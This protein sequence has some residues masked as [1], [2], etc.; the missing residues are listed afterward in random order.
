[1]NQ[2]VVF[3]CTRTKNIKFILHYS[4]KTSYSMA[5]VAYLNKNIV[6]N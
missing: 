6:S 1:M 5:N 3:K 2:K 4:L